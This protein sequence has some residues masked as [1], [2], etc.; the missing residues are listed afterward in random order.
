MGKIEELVR[1]SVCD[2]VGVHVHDP[3]ELSLLP[4]VDLGEGRVKVRAVHE[5]QIGGAVVSNTRDIDNV[6]IDGLRGV[7]EMTV[8]R[9]MADKKMSL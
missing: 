8:S 3:T 7:S 9:R 6:V 5:I 4:E 2:N 1:R